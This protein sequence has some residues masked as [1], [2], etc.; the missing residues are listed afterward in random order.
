M[1]IISTNRA[2]VL[3]L[4]AAV[5]AERLGFDEDEALTLGKAACR[6]ECPVP[7]T[8]SRR[9]QRLGCQGRSG[10]E[11]DRE[12]GE[13]LT[14]MSHGASDWSRTRRRQSDCCCVEA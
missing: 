10:P 14:W 6:V 2:P 1:K 3:T 11:I 12:V 13:D 9:S 5:F 8:D 7:T 4:W